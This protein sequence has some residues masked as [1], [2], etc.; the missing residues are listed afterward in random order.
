M[1]MRPPAVCERSG[2]SL[3]SN[4]PWACGPERGMHMIKNIIFDMGNVLMRF[5]PMALASHFASS[6]EDQKLLC[7]HVF[8]G[9]EWYALDAGSI[10]EEDALSSILSMMPSRLHAA[11]EEAFRNWDRYFG[12]IQETNDYARSLKE[13]GYKLYLLSNAGVR[14]ARYRT[15]IPV[16][17][18]FDGVIVSAYVRQVKPDRAIYETLFSTYELEPAECFFIDDNEHNVAAAL[19][20][21]MQ[22]LVFTGPGP[23]PSFPTLF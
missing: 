10:D 11:A 20:C 4:K 7:E 17:D 15:R 6:Q 13:R 22:G 8:S 9:P 5:D 12:P 14:F 21:G 1:A 16:Y 19:A 18:C 2:Y 3:F 23:L